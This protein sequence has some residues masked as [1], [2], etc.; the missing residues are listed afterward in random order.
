MFMYKGDWPEIPLYCTRDAHRRSHI[1]S[2]VAT[3]NI[4][5]INKQLKYRL[6]NKNCFAFDHL[7]Q[8]T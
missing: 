2:S 6:V 7:C 1:Y 5:K 3:R 8:A 4:D